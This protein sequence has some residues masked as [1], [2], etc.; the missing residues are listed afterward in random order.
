MPRAREKHVLTRAEHL[1]I[2]LAI[3]AAAAFFACIARRGNIRRR[4]LRLT[5]AGFLAGNELLWYAWRL[6]N[7]GFRFPEGLPLQWCDIT[8]WLTVAAAITLRA[9]VSELAYYGGLGGS[10]MALLTPDLWTPFP[11]YPAVY[12]FLAHGGVFVTLATLFAGRMA[13]PGAGSVA[14][15]WIFYAVCASAV[16]IFNAVF[17][18]NYMYLR[19]KP[20]A[21][22]LLD[23]LGP[24]PLYPFTASALAAAIFWALW[25]PFRR[26]R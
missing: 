21:A 2:L 19:Q 23:V 13:R 3:A 12:F 10:A 20:D 24:W 17:G 18:T 6:D 22:S 8:L 11:S 14:R 26:A 4:R 25:L 9:R 5:L 7:E 15:A 16:G 1:L